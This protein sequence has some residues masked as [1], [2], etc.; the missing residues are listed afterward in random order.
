VSKKRKKLMNDLLKARA[1]SV[2]NNIHI[3]LK[4]ITLHARNVDTRGDGTLLGMGKV[5]VM[6]VL[7]KKDPKVNSL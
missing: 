4:V 5:F 2:K 3:P 1:L 7:K 6:R